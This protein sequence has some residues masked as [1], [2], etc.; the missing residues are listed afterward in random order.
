MQLTSDPSGNMTPLTLS[1]M[2]R[3]ARR[4]NDL[5]ER[6]RALARMN[7]SVPDLASKTGVTESWLYRF[8]NERAANVDIDK[9]CTLY[10]AL[11]GELEVG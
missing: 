1:E 3:F 5:V 10:L 4:N 9:V 2:V 8:V 7:K 6:T 11:V